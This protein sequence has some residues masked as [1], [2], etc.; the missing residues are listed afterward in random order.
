LISNQI[1]QN[2]VEG[3]SNITQKKIRILER[4]GRPIANYDYLEENFDPSHFT[5]AF[6]Y[7]PAESQVIQGHQFTKVF[8]NGITEYVI[9]VQGDDN[10]TY[11]IARTTAF[12]IQSLLVAYKERFDRD[13]FIKNLLMD[14]LLLV[15]IYNRAKKLQV[16]NDVRRAVYL[17]EVD[18][19]KD[20][21][22]LEVIRNIF[23]AKQKDFV[24]SIDESTIVLVKELRDRD[25]TVDIERYAYIVN[26]TL[27]AE[28]MKRGQV[29]IGTV[30]TDL[31]FVSASYKEAKMALEVGKIF[32]TDKNIVNYNNLGIGRL[33]YQLPLSICRMFLSEILDNSTMDS[34]DDELLTTVNKFFENHLNVS[35]TSRQLYIHRNTLVY[36]LD[37]LQKITGLDLRNFEDAILFQIT[38]MVSK[39]L[40]YKE[41]HML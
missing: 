28:A 19:D 39:Y 31:K 22:A 6:V 2:T 20:A 1:L 35:E 11:Q 9:V 41:R 17:I 32:E 33:I 4:D 12:H 14:N 24:T 25:T 5:E 34:F 38:L 13:N 40:A 37:K 3:L 30:V 10:E 16:E 15:D 36:R 7:S 23:P 8:D 26:D 21:A 18:A 29:A 27:A